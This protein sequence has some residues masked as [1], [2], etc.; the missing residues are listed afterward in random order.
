MTR[1]LHTLSVA[2]FSMSVA[3]VASASP[4]IP[5]G[6]P[7]AGIPQATLADDFYRWILDAPASTN[8]LFDPT[9]ALAHIN[10]NGPVSLLA[11]SGGGGFLT[12]SFSVPPRKPLFVPVVTTADIELPVSMDPASCLGAPDPTAC[13]L[14]LISS[15]PLTGDLVARLDGRRSGCGL[16]TLLSAVD[17]PAGFLAPVHRQALRDKPT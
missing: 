2:A 8:P 12:R 11:G 17:C 13:A 14:A 9:G 6:T 16:H 7:D 1:F 15:F 4:V 5:P 10:N 3:G